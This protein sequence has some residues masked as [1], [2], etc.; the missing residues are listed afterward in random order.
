[1]IDLVRIISINSDI[2]A[3]RAALDKAGLFIEGIGLEQRGANC[4]IRGLSD[5]QL[6]NVEAA[7]D[8][9]RIT[10]YTDWDWDE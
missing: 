4:E 9:A 2:P 3:A 8:K 6:S 1:M 7:L 5:D 10:F